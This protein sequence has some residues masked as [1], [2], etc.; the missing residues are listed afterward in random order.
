M[1]GRAGGMHAAH[2]VWLYHTHPHSLTHPPLTHIHPPLT[3]P[4]YHLFHE[5]DVGLLGFEADD[6]E[7]DNGGEDGS[8]GVCEADNQ[9]VSECVVVG[10]GVAG[11]GYERPRGHT[12]REEYLRGRLQPHLR[13]HQ[14]LPLHMREGERERRERRRGRGRERGREGEGEREREGVQQWFQFTN[15]ALLVSAS[16]KCVRHNNTTVESL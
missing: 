2:S 13:V 5:V 14:L 8:E 10:L 16:M 11:Q 7:H 1:G 6:A 15:K 9:R 12:Q 4:T 3:H